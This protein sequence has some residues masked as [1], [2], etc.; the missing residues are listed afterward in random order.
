MTN[1]S[2]FF[3]FHIINNQALRPGNC[4]CL[5]WAPLSFSSR[6]ER[7]CL[8]H[9]FVFNVL[10]CYQSHLRPVLGC[11]QSVVSFSLAAFGLQLARLPIQQRADEV[12]LER[13]P[14]LVRRLSQVK[15]SKTLKAKF[16][17]WSTRCHTN[18]SSAVLARKSHPYW[19]AGVFH[20]GRTELHKQPGYY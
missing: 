9:D 17:H 13:A 1:Y 5:A 20:H 19:R 15:H 6:L 18:V 10:G 12:V 14:L 7:F 8:C 16:N 3:R 11:Y 4:T 2:S